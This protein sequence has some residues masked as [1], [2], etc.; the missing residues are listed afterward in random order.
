MPRKAS[1]KVSESVVSQ[2]TP[3]VAQEAPVAK[4]TKSSRSSKKAVPEPVVVPVSSPS[5]VLETVAETVTE[6]VGDSTKKRL[7]P[8]RES[9]ELEFDSLVTSIDEEVNRLRESPSKAKGVKFLRSINKRLKALRTHA[10][11]V[12]KQRK[13]SSRKGNTNS[14]FLKPVR[15]SKELAKFTG[16]DHAQE[17]SRVDVTKYICDYIKEHELQNP[18]DRRQIRVDEDSKLRN[19]LGY[20]SK[21]DKK[22]LTYYSLQTYLKR[23]FLPVETA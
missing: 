10:L 15:I 1:K 14:G 7:V 23:H 20:D 21:K 5:P 4:A 22:P 11:R 17:R 9:V 12:A 8:T 6:S 13:A 2:E 3:V 18:E 19:L 16:W